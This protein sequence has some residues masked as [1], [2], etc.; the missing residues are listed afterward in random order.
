MS[1]EFDAEQTG[2]STVGGEVVAQFDVSQY[3]LEDTAI[4]TVQNV[5]R[6]DDMLYQGNPVRITIYSPGS[7]QGVRALH[8]A[9]QQAQLRMQ[10]LFRGKVDKKAAEQA[11]EE[12]ADKLTMLTASIEN[13]PIPGGAK[14]IYSNPKL[15]DIADQVEAFFNE[16]SN[17]S[18]A[19]LTT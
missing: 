16:K 2:V 18:K 7:K 5:E 14:S 11:D 13:F 19:S 12:R 1:N 4:L 17:F 3:E 6:S 15:I 8:R 10:A 9:G